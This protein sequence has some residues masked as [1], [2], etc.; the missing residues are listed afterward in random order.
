M[1]FS[2]SLPARQYNHRRYDAD[3]CT[4]IELQSGAT[5]PDGEPE[6]ISGRGL[7]RLRGQL[8]DQESNSVELLIIL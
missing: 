4:F 8:S 6:A 2:L 1:L 5:I 7:A 3:L